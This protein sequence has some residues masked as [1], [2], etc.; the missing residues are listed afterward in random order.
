MYK[1]HVRYMTCKFMF[2]H[3]ESILVLAHINKN[4]SI[5]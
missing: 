1:P 3:D 4:V 2:I 5:I